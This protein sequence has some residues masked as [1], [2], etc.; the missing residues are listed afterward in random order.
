M[1]W[2]NS[3]AIFQADVAFIIEDEIPDTTNVF[4]DDLSVKGPPTQYKLPNGRYETIPDNP[5]IQQFMWNISTMFIVFFIN[6]NFSV[7]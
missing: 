5:G 3:V 6:L 4:I 2:S 1:G 7:L